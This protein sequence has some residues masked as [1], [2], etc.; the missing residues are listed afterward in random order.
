MLGDGRLVNANKDTNPDLWTALKGSQNNLGV[1]TRFDI[2]A[3]EQGLLWGGVA[4]YNASTIPKQIEAFIDFTD[5]VENDPYG[6]LIFDWIYLAATDE[7]YL[8]NIYDYTTTFA[9]NLTSYPPAFHAFSNKSA[10]GPPEMSTL[11]LANL[12]SLT[13]ELNSPPEL[14]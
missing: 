9:N 6:S 7:T 10:I 2:E 14:R 1:I 4:K 11:R 3:F 13:G 8:E 5:N 12:S